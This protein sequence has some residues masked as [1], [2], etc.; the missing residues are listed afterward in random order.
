M[1]FDAGDFADR[2]GERELDF[3]ERRHGNFRRQH[4]VEHLVVAQIAVRQYVVAQPL[5]GAQAAAMADHQPNMRAQHGE[6][7]GHRFC[8]RRTDADV[9]QRDAVVTRL[10]EMIGR[11]LRQLGERRQRGRLAAFGDAIARLDEALGAAFLDFLLAIDD[12][13]IDVALIVGE[14]H[15]A[16]E[17][18]RIG[19][20]I[21]AQPVQRKIDAL[22]G[23]QRQ[24]CGARPGPFSAVHHHV[25]GRV[26]TGQRKQ[27]RQFKPALRI[28][29]RCRAFHGEGQRDRVAAF[30]DEYRR[31]VVVRQQ[32][33]LFDQI[34]L[35]QTRR[36]DRRAV[37]AGFGD[38]SEGEIGPRNVAECHIDAEI[39][40]GRIAAL[41]QTFVVRKRVE[42]LL[43]FG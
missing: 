20:R 14:Q 18:R 19:T 11:H 32:R 38:L 12:E 37:T 31:L 16:L 3:G 33:E 15:E 22:G 26:Q 1:A 13:L 39:G 35:E 42:P 36:G 28:H 29:L 6:M 4:G 41:R 34:V 9:H 10:R 17:M 21:M 5:I 40:I 43:D 25:V 27:L 7:I 8:V 30:A 23:E 24:R 2:L